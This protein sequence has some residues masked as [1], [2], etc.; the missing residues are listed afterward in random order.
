MI[1]PAALWAEEAVIHEM[2]PHYLKLE[3]GRVAYFTESTETTVF[4]PRGTKIDLELD[5]NHYV[6]SLRPAV[7]KSIT[8]LPIPSHR[9][10]DFEPTVYSTYSRAQTAL[11]VFRFPDA[12]GSQCYDRAHIWTYEAE[13]FSAFRLSKMWLFFSDHYIEANN[14]KW[15]FHVAPAALVNMKGSVENRIMDRGF[16]KYPLKTKIWTDLFMIQKQD[17]RVVTRYTDYSEHP[18]EEDCYLIEST[19]YYWQPRDL[20]KLARRSIYKSQYIDSEVSHAYKQGFGI[21]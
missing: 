19:P 14:F 4:Y 9:N 12:Q 1:L 11:N 17:C 16:S 13:K 20:E 2:R 3:D 6:T 7:E 18:N 21:P 15:W 10:I 8:R 5:Q